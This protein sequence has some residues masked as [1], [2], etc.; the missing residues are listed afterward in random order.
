MPTLLTDIRLPG[1]A[2]EPRSL[3]IVD[4]R[5]AAVG[6][7]GTV[8]SDLPP[9]LVLHDLAGAVVLPGL[10]DAH[11]HLTATGFLA[12]ALDATGMADLPSLLGGVRRA[13]ATTPAGELVLGLRV[14]PDVLAEGRPPTRAE[15]DAA[16]PDHA[17]YLRHLTGHASYANRAAFDRLELSPAMRG[18]EVDDD[19]EPT[20]TLT[21]PSTQTATHRAYRAFSH[22]VGYESA[23][24]AA[25]QRAVR[26]GCTTVHALDDLDAVRTLLAVEDDLPVRTVAYPQTFDLESVRALG[27]QRIGGC[28]ACALDG[29]VDV[30]TAALLEA[31]ADDA[32]AFG[33]L[34]HNDATLR[35]FVLAAHH[36]GMQ[37]AFHAVGDRAV[38]QALRMYEAAQASESRPNAR[39]RIEHA[40]IVADDHAGRARAVG[41][42]M[43]LQ[44]AFNRAWSHDTYLSSI[45]PERSA[46]VD[47]LR[48]FAT[49]GLTL[50]GG[51]D[52]T[53]TELAPLHGVHAAVHHS[54]AE[55]RL[56]VIEALELF[57]HGVAYAAHQEDRRGRLAVGYDADLTVVDRDPLAVDP[58]DLDRLAVRAT[59]VRGER[60]FTA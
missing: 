14:D 48:S 27:L 49:A 56:G 37:L 36:A 5:I 57:S 35:G 45:G 30:R 54:R 26:R 23:F 2:D 47:P 10:G 32:T 40:Q 31:Y 28:H 39:H 44:P 12:S 55:E 17:V 4:G 60:V 6:A 58:G 50:A 8:A 7:S 20:G 52:S 13:A 34:Y 19:G 9:E 3:L 16:A 15:L 1:H 38:D 59:Y 11:V 33:Q 25:S 51:S 41:A 22:Q 53:V 43:S 18:V 21:G 24:H 42:V 46:K 29:D